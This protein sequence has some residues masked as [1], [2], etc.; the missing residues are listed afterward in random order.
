VTDPAATPESIPPFRFS[1][2]ILSFNDEATLPACLASIKGCD[3]IVLL[4]SGSTDRTLEIA[5]E[6]GARIYSRPFDTFAQ[7]RNHAQRTI[8]FRHP[9]LLHLNADE[10]PAV[11]LLIEC[12][13]IPGLEE[14]HGFDVR[15]KVH[16]QGKWVRRSSCFAHRTPRFVRVREFQFADGPGDAQPSPGQTMDRLYSS[17]IWD[18]S[19]LNPGIGRYRH[20]PDNDAR[21]RLQHGE[22][23][24]GPLA[25][26][27]L[28]RFLHRYFLCGGF[29]EGGAGWNYC[30]HLARHEA[31]TIEAM[32]RLR[33]Q[34]ASE[35]LPQP[36]PV[37]KSP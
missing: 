4:D 16:W 25:A 18:A 27:P 1:I 24:P 6:A 15:T 10:L 9:W 19:A 3:D 13:G 30:R 23:I 35:V 33:R 31:R 32:R 7:Q 22:K 34:T 11:P 20:H 14:A 5:R 12:D 17:L 37:R 28:R 36:D 29:L 26:R 21:W 2:L 8:Q